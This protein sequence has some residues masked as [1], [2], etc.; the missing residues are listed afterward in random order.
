MR[1]TQGF[2]LVLGLSVSISTAFA[3]GKAK[4]KAK[5][6]D[7]WIDGTVSY[8]FAGVDPKFATPEEACKAGVD[9]LAKHGNKKTFVSAKDGTTSTSMSCAVKEADG[10]ATDLTNVVS[11]LLDCPETTSPRSTDNSGEFS[12]MRCHCDDAK[13]CPAPA[14][15]A[16][17]KP[18]AKK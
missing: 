4:P 12:K 8:K 2:V 6:K 7:A 9:D 15:A 1:I 18:A 14:K 5:A 13:G 10:G 11:K 3:G 16:P 17:A